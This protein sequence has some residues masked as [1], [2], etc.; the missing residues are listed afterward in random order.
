MSLGAQNLP[1]QKKAHA[2]AAVVSASADG[3]METHLMAFTNMTADD[4]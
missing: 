2:R 4:L 3:Q 1:P